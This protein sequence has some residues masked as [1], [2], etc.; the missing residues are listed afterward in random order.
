MH[1]CVG[2][3]VWGSG[4]AVEAVDESLNG[5]DILAVRP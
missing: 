5:G 2:F 1:G 3:A 4:H